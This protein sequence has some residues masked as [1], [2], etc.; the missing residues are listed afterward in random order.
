[1]FC[2]LDARSLSEDVDPTA[3]LVKWELWAEYPDP[4]DDFNVKDMEGWQT[5]RVRWNQAAS[6]MDGLEY[7]PVQE[8]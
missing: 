5:L 3:L 7:V 8:F 6:T 1:M 2:I 4:N